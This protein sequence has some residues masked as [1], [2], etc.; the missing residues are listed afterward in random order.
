MSAFDQG[1][2]ASIASVTDKVRPVAIGAAVT[3]VHFLGERAAFVGVEESV[4]LVDGQDEISR[5]QVL[6]GGILCTAKA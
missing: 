6:S 1:H 3:A 2:P 5:V 4:S